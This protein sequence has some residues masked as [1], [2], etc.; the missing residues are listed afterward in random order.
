MLLAF[1][2]VIAAVNYG[3]SGMIGE[4]TGLN[5]W[6]ESSTGG[7]FKGFSL[8][9]IFGQVFRVFAWIIG[10]QCVDF[11]AFLPLHQHDVVILSCSDIGGDLEFGDPTIV[12]IQNQFAHGVDSTACGSHWYSELYLFHQ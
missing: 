10:A 12:W 11:I 3:L 7:Q 2:A 5:A 1:I 8:E 6:V 4:Y 9:Y